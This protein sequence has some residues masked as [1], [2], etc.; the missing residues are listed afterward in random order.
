MAI[1]KLTS[2][3]AEAQCQERAW[4]NDTDADGAS[5]SDVQKGD[6]DSDVED[7]DSDDEGNGVD[8]EVRVPVTPA[9]DVDDEVRVPVT[10]AAVTTVSVTS[11]PAVTPPL[12]DL[13]HFLNALLPALAPSPDSYTLQLSMPIAPSNP[14][15][16]V[17]R[18]DDKGVPLFP[19]GPSSPDEPWNG[20]LL[21]GS[22]LGDDDWFPN[23]YSG[24]IVGAALGLE[25]AAMGN[26]EG[27][28]FMQQVATMSAHDMTLQN[29]FA[30][31]RAR[32]REE[33]QEGE[34]VAPESAAEGE[35]PRPK[36]MWRGARGEQDEESTPE[37]EQ[38]TGGERADEKT[39]QGEGEGDRE[40]EKLE[41]NDALKASTVWEMDTTEW[42]AE[43]R[44]A[45]SACKRVRDLGGESWDF[46]IEGLIALEQTGGFATKSPVPAPQGNKDVRPEEVPTFMRYAQ[47]WDKPVPLKSVPSP[48]TMKGSFA[49]RWWDWWA[50]IQ[51]TSRVLPS[52][53]FMSSRFVPVE[54]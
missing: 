43:L 53:K 39:K 49:E 31:E 15:A 30:E 8:D 11:A 32:A 29:A 16:H 18:D 42:P 45:I 6:Q 24:P 33:R 37:A 47:K 27:L 41:S 7:D 14:V 48:I 21:N 17:V 38:P 28:A 50:R 4:T 52:G 34:R 20:L 1:P 35:R 40:Q 54:D 23:E 2:Y 26:E 44:M 13:T 22:A 5:G 25:I 9:A 3:L 46:C 51:P 36:P 10:P 12:L 19:F